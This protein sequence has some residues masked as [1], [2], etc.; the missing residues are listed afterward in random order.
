MDKNNQKNNTKLVT[1][2]ITLKYYG[3][4]S[5]TKELLFAWSFAIAILVDFF[6]STL[7]LPFSDKLPKAFYLWFRDCYQ[8]R[9]G[10]FWSY[11]IQHTKKY[12]KTEQDDTEDPRLDKAQTGQKTEKSSW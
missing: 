10:P 6:S 4:V 11:F 7:L 12:L 9:V 8:R 5:L 2:I 1:T 3:A